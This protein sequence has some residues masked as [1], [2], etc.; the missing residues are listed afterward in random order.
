MNILTCFLAIG[1]F[2]PQQRPAT[3]VTWIASLQD[4]A[5]HD[6]THYR[7]GSS[8]ELT[9]AMAHRPIVRSAPP[10]T[11]HSKAPAGTQSTPG[12]AISA[13]RGYLWLGNGRW[14]LMTAEEQRLWVEAANANYRQD[15][16]ADH[17]ARAGDLPKAR[18]ELEAILVRRPSDK[19]AAAFLGDVCVRMELYCEA[20]AVLGP[21]LGTSPS[22]D[23]LVRA[24]VSGAMTNHVFPGQLRFTNRVTLRFCGALTGTKESLPEASGVTAAQFSALTAMGSWVAMQGDFPTAQIYFERARQIDSNN[25]F[26]QYSLGQIYLAANDYEDA[27]A[28][29]VVAADHGSGDIRMFS[30]RQ[31]DWILGQLRAGVKSAK[32]RGAPPP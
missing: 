27:R 19:V 17:F 11:D 5:F 25:A 20:L 28:A 21:L 30:Q 8:C 23:V 22:Q 2:L 32:T 13:D 9:K 14:R 3:N 31:A 16:I 10:S 15:A 7:F 29:Y 4:A 6:K 1:A 24:A 18:S 12:K 26:V